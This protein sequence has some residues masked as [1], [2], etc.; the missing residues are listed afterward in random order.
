MF[1]A[2]VFVATACSGGPALADAQMVWCSESLTEGYIDDGPIT[3]AAIALDVAT[4]VRWMLIEA[5]IDMEID[6]SAE[7]QAYMFELS[8]EGNTDELDEIEQR[9]RDYYAQFDAA[10]QADQRAEN[11]AMTASYLDTDDGKRACAAA[12]EAQP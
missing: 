7:M 1:T 8:Y 6:T 11:Q 2:I 3:T 4:P 10:S 9:L 12:F 5:G